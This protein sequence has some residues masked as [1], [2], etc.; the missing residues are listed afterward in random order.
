MNNRSH[1]LKSW[2]RFFRAIVA[3]ERTHELRRND[4]DF[5]V[6]DSLLLHEWDHDT[7]QYTGA[8][9][10][11]IVSSITTQEVPCAVSDEG[12]GPDF[13]ILSIHVLSTVDLDLDLGAQAASP[14]RPN[15]QRRAL[16]ASKRRLTHPLARG[17]RQR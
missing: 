5:R 11:A 6:G 16:T 17:H 9:C 8:S 3:G 15:R 13:A 1:H 2:P 10:V 12:L 14:L 4:R 7:E